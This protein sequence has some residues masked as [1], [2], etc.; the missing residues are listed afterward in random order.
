MVDSA[1]DSRGQHLP[2]PSV[3]VASAVRIRLQSVL[4]LLLLMMMMMMILMMNDAC[5]VP[6]PTPPSPYIKYDAV[7]DIAYSD[8][9]LCYGDTV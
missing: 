3:R 9:R 2:L 6:H 5:T 7:R 4:L 1:E 8:A